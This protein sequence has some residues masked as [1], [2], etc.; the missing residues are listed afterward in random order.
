MG[1]PTKYINRKNTY[2][3]KKNCEESV[4][5]SIIKKFSFINNTTDV[6]RD[7][8][9]TGLQ[10]SSPELLLNFTSSPI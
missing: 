7:V 5:D 1:H 4:T 6:L 9:A 8:S 3:N 2:I 10:E